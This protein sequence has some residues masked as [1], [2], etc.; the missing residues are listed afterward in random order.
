ME[1]LKHTR[2][3][4]AHAARLTARIVESYVGGRAAPVGINAAAVIAE[5]GKVFSELTAE[6][7]EVPINFNKATIRRSKPKPRKKVTET[8]PTLPTEV[9]SVAETNKPEEATA[10]ADNNWN[11]IV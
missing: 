8:A 4:T 9:E 5:V 11:K 1:V 2:Q 7:I 3:S 10:E 6:R